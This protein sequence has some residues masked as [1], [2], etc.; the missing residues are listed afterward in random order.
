[1]NSQSGIDIQSTKNQA[2]ES[3]IQ[4][5][6]KTISQHSVANG[7]LNMPKPK[8]VFRGSS[9]ENETPLGATKKSTPNN[10]NGDGSGM[11]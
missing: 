2:N 1:M 8:K 9:L 4:A 7:G 6:R 11:R 3:G 5:N 10:E